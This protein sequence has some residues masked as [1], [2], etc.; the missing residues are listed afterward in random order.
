M[1]WNVICLSYEA[2]M[3][4]NQRNGKIARGIEDLRI[5]GAQ[6]RLSHFLGDG[7]QAVLQ[8]GDGDWVDH[9]GMLPYSSLLG[10]AAGPSQTRRGQAIIGSI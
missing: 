7:V 2:A 10:K 1:D 6:H 8:N 4:I 9:I 3:P 5:G